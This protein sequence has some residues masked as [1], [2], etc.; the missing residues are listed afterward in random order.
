M[1]GLLATGASNGEIA[2]RLYLSEKTVRNVVSAVFARAR[3]GQPGR[4]G[5]TGPGRRPRWCRARSGG[6]TPA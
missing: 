6:L 5:G 1:L 4:G 2:G 3:G